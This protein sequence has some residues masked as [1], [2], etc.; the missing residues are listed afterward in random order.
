MYLCSYIP[1]FAFS[2]LYRF[3]YFYTPMYTFVPAGHGTSGV[4]GELPACEHYFHEA[5]GLCHGLLVQRQSEGAVLGARG[6]KCH[7][8][9]M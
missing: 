5:S 8:R 2:L 9:R 4:C 7:I 3:V 1:V 6:E